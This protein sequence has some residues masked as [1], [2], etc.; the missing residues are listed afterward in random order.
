MNNGI[1]Q[2]IQLLQCILWLIRDVFTLI[3]QRKL[4]LTILSRFYAFE[5]AYNLFKLINGSGSFHKYFL[6]NTIGLSDINCLFG[7]SIHMVSYCQAKT[8]LYMAQVN[9]IKKYVILPIQLLRQIVTWW[10][11][12]VKYF[13][14]NF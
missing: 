14:F 11:N 9:I 10:I 4:C 3:N 12:V 8:Y 13:I 5:R 7:L 1:W 2:D 6:P